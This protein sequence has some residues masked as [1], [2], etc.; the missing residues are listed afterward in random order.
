MISTTTIPSPSYH[1]C[2]LVGHILV[3]VA[4]A[5]Y[6]ANGYIMED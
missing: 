1:H 4:N 6:V 2:C 5:R 3:I